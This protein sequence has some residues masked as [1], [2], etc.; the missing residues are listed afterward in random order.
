MNTQI[1][2]TPLRSFALVALL[3]AASRGHAQFAL[4]WFTLDGGGGASAGGS[5]S[6]TG[7]IGQPDAGASSGGG[8]TLQGGFWPGVPTESAPALR[9]LRDGPNVLLAWPNPATGFQLQESSSLTAP[10]WTD[11]NAAPALVG[12]EKQ[13]SQSIAPDT[14]FYRLRKP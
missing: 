3:L 14:R 12:G 13:V 1:I 6:L 4:D 10:D 5:Y 7:T 2:T 9:I 8:Y 11:V